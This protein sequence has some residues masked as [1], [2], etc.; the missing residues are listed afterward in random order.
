MSGGGGGGGG[1]LKR[2][3]GCFWGWKKDI[4]ATRLKTELCFIYFFFV[5]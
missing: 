1:V 5:V 3:G 4:N 2:G